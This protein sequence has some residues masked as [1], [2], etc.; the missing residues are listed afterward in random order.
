MFFFYSRVFKLQVGMC[1]YNSRKSKKR[2]NSNRMIKIW[3]S[4][5]PIN[6]VNLKVELERDFVFSLWYH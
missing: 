1:E 4:N 3:I 6:S 2:E 5:R